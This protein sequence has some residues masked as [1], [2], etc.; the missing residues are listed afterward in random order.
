MSFLT[1]MLAHILMV[2]VIPPL[3]SIA[4]AGSRFDPVVRWPGLFAPVPAALVELVVV[5]GWHAPALNLIARDSLLVWLLEQLCFLV[6]GLWVWLAAFGG[7]PDERAGRSGAGIVALLMTF[8]H[9][10]LLGALLA[11]APRALY[12]P[13]ELAQQQGGGVIMLLGA[14]SSYLLG[15]LW[16]LRRLLQAPAQRGAN[17]EGGEHSDSG[18]S[19]GA[20]PERIL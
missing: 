10:T 2:A 13:G 7:R 12:G 16:L 1:H 18:E 4:V 17:G 6:T 20:P 11:L 14:G 15:G 9:M 19:G 5:W 8:M 3:L